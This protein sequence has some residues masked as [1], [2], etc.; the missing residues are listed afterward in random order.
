MSDPARTPG[1]V[2]P[3][4]PAA[5]AADRPSWAAMLCL[6]VLS[7][8]LFAPALQYELVYDDWFLI[9]GNELMHPVAD[10]LA[11][12][13]EFFGHEYWA[14]VRAE[15]PEAL[16]PQGQALYRP[17]TLFTWALIYHVQPTTWQTP[18]APVWAYHLV[19]I[20]LNAVVV[21]LLYGLVLRLTGRGRV[22]FL[23][24]ALFAVHP[25]HAE[26]VTYVNGLSDLLA[27]LAI[28]LG[29]HAYLSATSG[30][31][32]RPGP[33]LGLLVVFFVGLLAKELAV[34]LL[35]IVPLVDLIAAR[36]GR[37]RGGSRL[38]VYGG[39]L[40]TFGAH[41]ALRYAVLGYLRPKTS[42]ITHIDNPLV[43]E[44]LATRLFTGLKIMG[45]QLWLFVW[46][47]DLSI[48]YS[49]NALPL[50]DSLTTPETLAALVLFGL[51]LV[52][53][54]VKM[55]RHPAMAFAVLLFVGT[56]LFFSNILL[57]FGTIFAERLT[58]LPTLGAALAVA[59]LLDAVVTRVSGGGTMPA[60][61]AL[62]VVVLLAA[63][64]YR[65]IER[66][67]DFRSRLTLW[68]ATADVAP[69][70]A[71]VHFNLGA[72][73][74]AEQLFGAAEEAYQKALAIDP[75]FL[76]AAISL[77]NTHAL[78]R[79]FEKA[80][81][82]YDRIMTDL[83]GQ[84]GPQARELQRIVYQRRG[85]AKQGAGDFD[86]ALFDLERAA[87]LSTGDEIIHGDA[88]RALAQAQ[89][90][91]GDHADALENVRQHLEN[92]PDDVDALFLL[93]RAAA[94]VD[95][96][97][98]YEE[99]LARLQMSESERARAAAK[100]MEAETLYEQSLVENDPVKRDQAL[101]MFEEVKGTN[102]ELATPYIYRGRYL[103]ERGD[104]FEAIIEFD[105]ALDRQP[106]NP[107]ALMFKGLAQLAA[108]RPQEALE[109]ARTLEGMQPSVPVYTIMAEAYFWLGDIEG[110]EA[111][112][113]KIEEHGESP[114]EIILQRIKAL[115]AEGR[116]D[117]AIALAEQTSVVPA[118]AG[119][120]MLQRSYGVLLYEAG[121][122]EE[123]LAAF[124]RQEKA[125]FALGDEA[126]PDPFLPINRARA[127]IGLERWDEAAAQL[128]RFALGADPDSRSYPSLLQYRAELAL[129]EGSPYR[130]PEEALRL[131][132]EGLERTNGRHPP[133]YDLAILAQVELGELDG[134]RATAQRAIETFPP[135]RFARET[136]FVTIE[137]AMGLA[138]DG[139]LERAHEVLEASGDERLLALSDA[140]ES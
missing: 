86:G 18:E 114:I 6:A 17:L 26:V 71:R 117:D 35:A 116:L 34:L 29:L 4:A 97:D 123:A 59:L 1:T 79:N 87:A 119:D 113:A 16:H 105:I 7:I 94:A 14:G 23:C 60:P 83:E 65:T 56:S 63:L 70:S 132:E 134:A 54:L 15:M 96:R 76:Q 46:P 47:K 62:V 5:A 37:P 136:R 21:L 127:L 107:A 109:T 91:R 128:D 52:W 93:A 137:G 31:S 72:S 78:D 42:L 38:A 101:A 50:S 27:T 57:P 12:A 102:P 106:N 84:T 2:P 122:H 48:D 49:F 81:D 45:M 41:L 10:S 120:P 30:S 67:R 111:A 133:F 99:A 28:L 126:A 90:D 55:G 25:L 104:Y 24:A 58:F 138:L 121:R 88:Q 9:A 108:G 92:D 82:V 13:L 53:G 98:T 135:D 110:M 139:D 32:L 125:Q 73:Y 74:S 39:L 64:G 36:A 85:L 77:G 140:L 11:A 103:A 131:A 33:Y 130:D 100:S 20:V 43:K 3:F 124:D 75:T 40:A 118:Y 95:D 89:F 129:A 69:E 8:G 115:E 44:D 61:A 112:Y 19:N 66:G 51:L 68:E 80:V 22:A